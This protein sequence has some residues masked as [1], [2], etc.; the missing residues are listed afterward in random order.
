MNIDEAIQKSVAEYNK[1][2]YNT[3]NSGINNRKPI[4]R[5]ESSN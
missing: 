5:K 2:H 4:N 3:D 1:Q